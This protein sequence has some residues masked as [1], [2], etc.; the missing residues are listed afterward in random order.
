MA[1]ETAPVT[2][3]LAFALVAVY[4]C[5][6]APGGNAIAHAY[7]LVPAHASFGTALSSMFL[8]DPSSW[9]HIGGN[10]VALVIF[11]SIVERALGS[12]RFLSL[13]AAAG[14]GGAAMHCLVDP[15]SSVPL[16]GCSGA[17]CGV[18]ALAAILRPRLIGFAVMFAGINVYYAFVGG[19]EHVSFGC[20]IGGFVVGVLVA[21]FLRA[22]DSEALELA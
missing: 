12:L 4:G 17:I 16:V 1:R 15:G 20:H 19:D 3:L 11:G 10:L 22:V 21:L 5:E 6:L 14:L 8:H 9:T 2:A 13:Y 7:G 18:L